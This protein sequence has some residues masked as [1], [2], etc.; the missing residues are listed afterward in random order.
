MNAAR[1]GQPASQIAGSFVGVTPTVYKAETY[2]QAALAGVRVWDVATG[3]PR[4]PLKLAAGRGASQALVSADGTKLVT[5]EARSYEPK[6]ATFVQHRAVFRDLSVGGPPVDLAEGFAMAAFT[7]DGKACVLATGEQLEGRGRLKLFD[8]I[9]GKEKSLFGDE[10]KANIFFSSF[11]ADGKLVSAE[12]RG[13]GESASV[14]KVWNTSSGKEM[15]ILK[16]FEPCFVFHPAFSPDGR[17]VMAIILKGAGYVWDAATGSVVLTR[18]FGEK[19]FTRELVVSPDSHW[20]ASVGT[21]GLNAADFGRDPDPADLPQP[22]V[23]LYDLA[24]AK[25]VKTMI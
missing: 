6:S 17:F 10:P 14:V 2:I 4:P 3:N 9:N 23:D 13:I 21:S 22:C 25:P 11:S 18:R 16:P 15:T 8:A 7:R 19:S 12:V 1:R 5:I 20:I 24:T